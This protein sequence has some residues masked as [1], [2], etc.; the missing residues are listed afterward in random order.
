MMEVLRLMPFEYRLGER[1][2]VSRHSDAIVGDECSNAS[3]IDRYS[4]R[5]FSC[6]RISFAASGMKVPGPKTASAPF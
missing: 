5:A 2:W 1:L 3:L 4:R 6:V